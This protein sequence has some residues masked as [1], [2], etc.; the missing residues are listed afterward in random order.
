MKMKQF[1][2]GAPFRTTLDLHARAMAD[3]G[4]LQGHYLGTR[5]GAKGV[6]EPLF[7]GYPFYGAV[8]YA[9]AKLLPSR[10]EE[11]RAALFPLFDLW[12]QRRLPSGVGLMTSFGYANRSM[13]KTRRDGGITMLDGGNSHY[14]HYW[15]I[16][17]EEHKRWGVNTP[18]LPYK[19][20]EAGLRSIELTDWVFARATF[21]L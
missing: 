14:A 11:S 20:Y 2:V 15:R 16:V 4:I 1:A 18:P 6:P 12:L 10:Q 13:E 17:W 8:H 7:H 9:A 5:R 19:W 21:R 3:L